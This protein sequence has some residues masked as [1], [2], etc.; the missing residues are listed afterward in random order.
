MRRFFCLGFILLLLGSASAQP[1][2]TNITGGIL[3]DGEPYLAINPSNPNNMVTAWMSEVIADKAVG[4]RTKRTT[5]GGASWADQNILPHFGTLWHSAD[6][7]MAF[8]NTGTLF[9]SYID[10]RQSPDSGGIYVARSTDGGASWGLPV[11]AFSIDDVAEKL[12]IDRPWLVVDNSPSS[13]QGTLYITTKPAP[14]VLPPNRPYFKRSTDAGQTWSGIAALDGNPYPV[15][16]VISAPMASPTVTSDGKF[17]VVYPSYQ[18]GKPARYIFQ[19]SSDLGNT[20]SRSIVIEATSHPIQGDTLSK[21]GYHLVADPNDSKRLAFIAPNDLTGDWDVMLITSSDGGTT[22]GAP[23]RVNDDQLQNGIWQD[24][25]WCS[26]DQKGNIIAAWRDRRNGAGIGYSSAADIYF[27][28]S[29]DNGNTFGKNIRLSNVTAP[30]NQVLN[31]S[32]NDFL[33]VD[34]VGDSICCVWGDV[35]SGRLSIYFAKAAVSDG[36]ASV[37]R[38]DQD[39]ALEVIPTIVTNSFKCSFAAT[40]QQID[41]HL[42]DMQGKTRSLELESVTESSCICKVSGDIPSGVYFVQ[43]SIGN[44]VSSQKISII[45]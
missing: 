13:T 27:A 32:G 45:R 9:I 40:T 16:S 10:S 8:T 3:F 11:K 4:I 21:L 20:F 42:V 14:W 37:H 33:C 6:V 35:R 44:S 7:S 22:W 15:G 1:A 26:Y 2:N 41:C 12:P 24:L 36:I 5:D 29:K 34:V 25:V 18:V 43:I 30:Y 38:I 39:E 23:V 17:S 19:R 31:G 28:V